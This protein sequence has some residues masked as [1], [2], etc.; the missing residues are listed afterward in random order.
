M[1]A[2]KPQKILILLVADV[3]EL[4]DALDSKLQ[5]SRFFAILG[6]TS[7]L[8]KTLILKAIPAIRPKPPMPVRALE[9][10]VDLAQKLAQH[11][12]RQ[13]R[14]FP[15]KNE[16]SLRRTHFSRNLVCLS[17][18][19]AELL[20]NGLA[21]LVSRVLLAPLSIWIFS[22]KTHHLPPFTT[23]RSPLQ[24]P[25]SSP[26]NRSASC[27][28]FHRCLDGKGDG[29]DGEEKAGSHAHESVQQNLAQMKNDKTAFD[30]NRTGKGT[31]EW[32]DF[33]YNICLG[34]E[35]E[36]LYC[37]AKSQRCRFDERM[38]RPGVWKRQ[39]LNPTRKALGAEVGAK[40]VV[41]FP[42]THDITPR[43]LKRS[44]KT[45]KNLL[46]NNQVLIVSKP[47]L[48]VVRALCKELADRKKDI[49]FR[50][51]I[52]SLNKSTCVF[53]EP[54]APPRRERIAALKH[55]FDRGFSTSVSIEPMLEDR[56]GICELVA[57]VEPYHPQRPHGEE[58]QR[59]E[60]SANLA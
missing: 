29:R 19:G 39:W 45:I 16:D 21:S 44:L 9:K 18:R 42:T 1:E 28:E 56:E 3:A 15:K 13:F 34:C 35:H 12:K 36:C 2:A 32:S 31:K 41:M 60:E 24:S 43:F 17:S 54:G 20:F 50:F 55:A 40:G 47:H 57:E 33:S 59:A 10:G 4:A 14:G 25:A 26:Q 52:G 58:P 51:T 46:A 5:F 22:K 38:R 11:P 49:L 8:A 48:L 53:W 27:N 23:H 7:D 37:Y 30:E 6:I